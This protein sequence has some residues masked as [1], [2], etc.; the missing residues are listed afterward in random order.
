MSKNQNITLQMTSVTRNAVP[1]RSDV[2]G[3]QAGRKSQSF[4]GHK[5]S[6]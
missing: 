2:V 3:E 5:D 1:M 6:N 4:E